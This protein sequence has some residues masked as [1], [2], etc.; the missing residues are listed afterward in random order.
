[1]IAELRPAAGS[2]FS[3][4]WYTL[5]LFVEFNFFDVVGRS[6][7]SYTLLF[8]KNTLWMASLCRFVLYPLFLLKAKHV[9]FSADYWSFILM[10]IFAVSNGY[11]ASLGMMYGPT[12]VEKDYEKETAGFIMSCFL[13]FGIFAGSNIA[14][15]MQ[16][17]G[18][19]V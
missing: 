19:G 10:G 8:S 6:L 9:I 2:A 1:M 15:L 7:P 13:T 5:T 4:D 18:I 17:C 11:V 14:L 3:A 16:S 12:Y